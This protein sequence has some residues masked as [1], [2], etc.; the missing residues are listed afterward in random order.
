MKTALDQICWAPVLVAG[1]FA[2]D[3]ARN[4]EALFP[5]TGAETSGTGAGAGVSVG[6]GSGDGGASPGGGL[7]G[8]LRR[9]LLATLKVN[10]SFWPLFH[11]VNFRF[12]N[13][14]DRILYVNVVQVLFN[15]FLCWK[16]SERAEG[17]G[18]VKETERQ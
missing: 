6:D 11:V 7:P 8:K 1:L 10:W 14:D 18:G 3:L 13:P 15:V 5:K 4:G 2:F 9:D 17:G 12:V 16:A